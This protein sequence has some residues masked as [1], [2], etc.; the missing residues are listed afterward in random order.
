MRFATILLS[1]SLAIGLVAAPLAFAERPEAAG[2]RGRRG[3]APGNAA[4]H[5]NATDDRAAENAEARAAREGAVASMR[6]NRSAAG[7]DFRTR[8]AEVRASFLEN[9]S[10]VI[11]ECRRDASPPGGN[12]TDDERR[13]FAHCVKDGLAPVKA[14]ARADFSA[15]REAFKARMA[16]LREAFLDAVRAWRALAAPGHD[17]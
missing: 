15:A 14:T 1:T 11:D 16:S 17:A 2:D 5:A 12:A 9:K 8:H 3:D 4:G 13:A 6:E 10:R 7:E